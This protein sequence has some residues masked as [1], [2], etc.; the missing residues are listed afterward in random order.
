[1]AVVKEIIV[2]S[3]E[4]SELATTKSALMETFNSFVFRIYS[5]LGSLTTNREYNYLNIMLRLRLGN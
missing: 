4:E 2:E 1:M 5:V 3:K